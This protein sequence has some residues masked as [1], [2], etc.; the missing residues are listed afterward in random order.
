[1][2]SIEYFII[3]VFCKIDELL[4]EITQTHQVRTKGFAPALSDSEVMT[5]EIVA[6]Y[7]GIDTDVGIWKYFR[8]HWQEWFPALKSRTTFVRQ[9]ANLWQYKA[10]LQEKLAAQLGALDDDVH[11]IDGVP[12]PLCYLCRASRCRSF[13]DIAEYGYCASKKMFYYGFHGHLLIS[14]RG[15]ITQFALTPA[16]GDER[17][18]L[19]DLVSNIH[20][21]LIGDKGYLSQPLRQ[22]LHQVAIDLE[23]ALRSNMHDS[24]PRWWVRL[25]V[26]VRRLIET[27]IGQ[28]VARFHLN[29]VWARDIWHLSSR[30]NR[31]IL[32]HTVCFW[33]NRHS[34]HPLQF[35]DL[36]D[37]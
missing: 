1:M 16:N 5:M 30:L 36:V 3:A 23:T 31:K 7:Q 18:T 22:D 10:M 11:L 26:K 12:I 32:S 28:L 35:E 9:A 37:S 19:W 20:G 4:K 15:V 25:I 29:K 14:G 21:F 34:L 2:F 17:E 8:D 13:E 6:E 27:V 33:L 24:R